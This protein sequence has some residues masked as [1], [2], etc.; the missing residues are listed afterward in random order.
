MFVGRDTLLKGPVG[1]G[2]IESIGV[3][4]LAALAQDDGAAEGLYGVHG[5]AAVDGFGER[6]VD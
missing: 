6:L 5:L 2:A 1:C 4:R 3:L